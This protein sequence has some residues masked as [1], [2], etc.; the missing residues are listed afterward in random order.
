[1][2]TL[3][4]LRRLL[5]PFNTLV[6]VHFWSGNIPTGERA[7]S[8]VEHKYLNPGQ[9]E[10]EAERKVEVET[11]QHTERIVTNLVSITLSRSGA[12][13]VPP[14][15]VGVILHTIYR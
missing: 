10:R 9:R 6:L 1:M 14:P 13:R 5:A 4:Q 3:T 2:A 15:L 12:N 11:G 8:A 7:F